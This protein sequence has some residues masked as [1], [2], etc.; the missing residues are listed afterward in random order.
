MIVEVDPVLRQNLAKRLSD[1]ER[2]I[3]QA[4]R[5]TEVKRMVK[6]NNID[7]A[8]LGLTSLKREGLAI[9]KM[10]KKVRPHTEVITLSGSGQVALSIEGMKLGA[11][12]DFM[13]PFTVESLAKRIHDA[14]LHKR[15]GEKKKKPLLRRYMDLMAAGAFAEAGEHEMALTYMEYEK[16]PVSG[17]KKEEKKNGKD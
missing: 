16:H 9:L 10:I 1:R 14:W 4:D 2:R 8:L 5:I 3:L 7:V 17:S 11:F 6:R 12:D 13:G 15:E